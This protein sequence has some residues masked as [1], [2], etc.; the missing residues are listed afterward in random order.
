MAL[1]I[2][3]TVGLIL[4][5]LLIIVLSPHVKPALLATVSYW[6]GVVL[7]VVGLLMLVT[8]VLIWARDQLRTML[9]V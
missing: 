5:G 1:M 7:L 8:P 4:A 9:Q 3:I 2:G 6:A